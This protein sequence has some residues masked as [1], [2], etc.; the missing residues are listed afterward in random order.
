MPEVKDLSGHRTQLA[1]GGHRERFSPLEEVPQPFRVV[2][3][4]PAEAPRVEVSDDRMK[5]VVVG[6]TDD[7]VLV[8]TV[9]LEELTTRCP[10]VARVTVV[11]EDSSLEGATALGDDLGAGRPGVTCRIRR[12]VVLGQAVA[13]LEHLHD[14]NLL[15]ECDSITCPVRVR[16]HQIA[17]EP[18]HVS[19]GGRQPGERQVEQTLLLPHEGLATH[20]D[21]VRG[22]GE[23]ERLVA[24]GAL[25]RQ[26]PDSRFAEQLHEDLVVQP[27]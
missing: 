27:P 23:V 24:E 18:G 3:E 10:A 6:R 13:G 9:S 26:D 2:L 15:E 12:R 20:L 25:N 19:A 22:L 17:V 5:H 14:R 1:F 16:E 11:L 7:G 21:D 8:Q 4:R